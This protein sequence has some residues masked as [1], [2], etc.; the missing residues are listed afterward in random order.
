M[1]IESIP[2]DP[3]SFHVVPFD[4]PRLQ[5]TLQVSTA[6]ARSTVRFTAM[7]RRKDR[8]ARS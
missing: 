4:N 6:P 7:S 1:L 5:Y 3:Y 8:A 2:G